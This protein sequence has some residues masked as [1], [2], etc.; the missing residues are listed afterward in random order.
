MGLERKIHKNQELR[1]KHSDDPTK[2]M[3]SEIE[4]FE[5]I[6]K[7]QAVATAPELYVEFVKLNG[8]SRVRRPC[9]TSGSSPKPFPHQFSD[10]NRPSSDDSCTLPAQVVELLDHEN[11]DVALAAVD[12]IHELTDPEAL[13]EAEEEDGAKVFPPRPRPPPQF[14]TRCEPLTG[15]QHSCCP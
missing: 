4:L 15:R 2:F 5:E 12:L 9:R 14:R 8:V 11:V 10:R 7:L 13:M 6:N 3:E 1:V